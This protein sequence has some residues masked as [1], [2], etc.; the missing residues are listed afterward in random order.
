MSNLLAG[1]RVYLAGPVEHDAKATSWRD[2]LTPW[3]RERG[4]TVY[5]PLVKPTWLDPICKLDPPL[6]RKALVGQVDGLTKA[7]V[8][9]ANTIMRRLCLAYVSSADWIIV[10]HPKLFTVGTF[11][12]IFLGANIQKPTFFCAPDGIISTWA[13]PVFSTPENHEKVFFPNWDTLQQHVVK[14]DS[15]EEKMD[16]FKWVSVC[17]PPAVQYP[18]LCKR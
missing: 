17:Y 5:D 11:E 4:I 7:Q 10:Y 16:P 3:L 8:F 13:L 1:T 18:S 6:Y 9:E 14:L 15:G 2:A 12:E